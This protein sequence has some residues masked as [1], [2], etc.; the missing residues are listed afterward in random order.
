MR[1]VDFIQNLDKGAS[2]IKQAL[3]L[4]K[5]WQPVGICRL[6]GCACVIYNGVKF[7]IYGAYSVGGGYNPSR[8]SYEEHKD[9]TPSVWS[10]TIYSEDHLSAHE[11]AEYIISIAPQIDH[12]PEGVVTIF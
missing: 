4:L 6:Y 1:K 12:A 7:S 3:E 5:N 2:H 9:G 11:I 8:V 10:K